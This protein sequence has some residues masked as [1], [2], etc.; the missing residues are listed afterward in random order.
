MTSSAPVREHQIE[1]KK[2][3]VF[4][5]LASA[6]VIREMTRALDNSAFTCNEIARPDTAQHRHWAHNMPLEAARQ[7]PLHQLTLEATR[8]M[9]HPVSGFALYRAYTNCVQ[10]G[11]HLY[12]HTDCLPDAGEL[13]ALWFICERWDVE[14]GGETLFY[15]RDMDA[16]AVVSPRPGRMVLFDGEITHCGTPP[17]R[18][19]L[20]PRY[21]YAM[22]LEPKQS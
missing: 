3:L 4:D 5:D 7:L 16:V 15:N 22:K 12:T 14:W 13:T 17:N 6:S 1:G 20:M 18:M 8:W 10:Y 19:C 2:V 9:E 21:T 11:D